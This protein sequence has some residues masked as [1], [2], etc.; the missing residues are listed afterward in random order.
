MEVI[1]LFPSA[2]GGG[3]GWNVSVFVYVLKGKQEQKATLRAVLI[4]ILEDMS[5]RFYYYEMI[6]MTYQN[7]V[8]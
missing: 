2:W 3:L 5:S 6:N 1:N 7:R 8:Q 4:V